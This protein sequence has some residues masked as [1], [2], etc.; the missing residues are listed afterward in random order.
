MEARWSIGPSDVGSDMRLRLPVLLWLILAPAVSYVEADE[1]R[2]EG[3]DILYTGTAVA[4]NDSDAL[5]RASAIGIKLIISECTA[6]PIGTKLF[7]KSVTQVPEGYRA[8]VQVGTDLDACEEIKRASGDRK[9]QLTNQSLQR[10]VDLYNA[11]LKKNHIP[12]DTPKV[13]T[14]IIDRLNKGFDGIQERLDETD[15]KLLELRQN[16]AGS[17]VILEKTILVGG[18]KEAC[19]YKYKKLLNKAIMAAQLNTPPLL[20]EGKAADY[21]EQAQE[22][23]RECR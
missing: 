15:A 8:I 5:F 16:H 13:E 9:S 4:I 18:S 1:R 14:G 10:D 11:W 12:D 3:S 20:T 19:E 17:K 2:I 21:Y 7:S 23:A 22:I 6:P